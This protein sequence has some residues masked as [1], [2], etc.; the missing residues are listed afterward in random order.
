MASKFT[1]SGD[2]IT[3][4]D[5][6]GNVTTWELL[7]P[8]TKI[9]RSPFGHERWAAPTLST[10]NGDAPRPVRATFHADV[11]LAWHAANGRNAGGGYILTDDEAREIA[12]ASFGKE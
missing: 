4:T 8:L 12:D 3:R 10:F 1:V 2:K 5:E 9:A 6:R 7:A 11:V